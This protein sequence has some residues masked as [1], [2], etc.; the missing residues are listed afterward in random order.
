LKKG[1]FEPLETVAKENMAK[2]SQSQLYNN[3]DELLY[4]SKSPFKFDVVNTREVYERLQSI[5]RDS[6]SKTW[7]EADEETL[8]SYF[9]DRGRILNKGNDIPNMRGRG[10]RSRGWW[11]IRNQEFWLEA[12]PMQL[13][14]HLKGELV[15]PLFREKQEEM[16]EEILND[17][18]VSNS[19]T[20]QQRINSNG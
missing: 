12:K 10:E 1:F 15:A 5:D 19:E 18:N 20:Q 11:T 13:R 2:A 8:R 4:D 3:L 7:Q 14:L 6:G 17:T 16:F 9:K